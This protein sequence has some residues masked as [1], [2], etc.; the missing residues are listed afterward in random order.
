MRTDP[1]KGCANERQTL[2]WALIHD[3]LA[4]LL[5]AL[6]GYSKWS[7]RFHDYTSHKAWPRAKAYRK[8]PVFR[9]LEFQTAQREEARLR[10]KRC[11]FCTTA[12]PHYHADGKIFYI[13]EVEALL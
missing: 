4:H 6:T 7:L 10:K 3:G 5:M 9:T 11:P 2:C 13:Y 1:R 8:G 12:A